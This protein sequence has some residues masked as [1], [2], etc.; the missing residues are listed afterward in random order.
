[1]SESKINKI[2]KS[3]EDIRRT[4]L[5]NAVKMLG[6]RGLV[7]DVEGEIKSVISK[8]DESQVYA[9]KTNK[10]NKKDRF[11]I[12]IIPHKITAIG[13]SFGMTDFL[14]EYKDTPKLVV[15]KEIGKKA[16][17][18]TRSLYQDT[19]VFKEIELMINLVDHHLVPKHILL[20][21]LTI[22][23]ICQEYNCKK[24]DVPRMKSTDP[25]A[26]YYNMKPGD[27]CRI[28]RPSEKSGMAPT[29]RYV[30]KGAIK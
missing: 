12:K 30:I 21:D 13:K 27:V 9:V 24:K 7:D 6:E 4:V 29:Y 17:M 28:L 19:E 1:M 2:N 22:E 14:D 25:I 3:V 15:V 5:T 8:K 26:K 10:N 23:K 16:E 18:L 20:P 11:M